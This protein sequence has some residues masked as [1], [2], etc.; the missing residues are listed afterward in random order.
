MVWLYLLLALA[1]GMG[2]PVQTGLNNS[3]RQHLGE[4]AWVVLVSIL[5]SAV[6]IASY[7]LLA[8]VPPPGS[9]AATQAP[10][11]AWLGGTIGAVYLLG[12][13]VL[14]AKL[15]AAPV[16]AAAVAG[17]MLASLLLDNWGLL[18]FAVHQL[19]PARLAGAALLVAGVILIRF[20]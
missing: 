17:Q 10:W 16:F 1:L 4:P 20:F 5:V 7:L 11:W 8:R 6:T 2:L 15:G 19:S 3:L 18:G 14:S 13:L 12:T 9:G